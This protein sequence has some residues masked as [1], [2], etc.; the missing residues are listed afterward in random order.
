MFWL[1]FFFLFFRYALVVACGLSCP[2]T[3]GILVP[4]PGIEPIFPDS[5]LGKESTCNEGDPG[6][7]PGSGRSHGERRGYPLQYSWAFLVA[8]LVKNLPTMQ[9][10]WV[11]FLGWEDTLEKG[12]ATHSS[13]LAW[14]CSPWGHT[15]LSNFHFHVSLSLHWRWILTHWT[16]REVPQF[17]IYLFIY[18]LTYFI[19]LSIYY[20]FIYLFICLFWVSV[21]AFRI[22]SCSMWTFS[23]SMWDLVPWPGTKLGS[24]TLGPLSL[25]CWT[26]REVPTSLF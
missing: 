14:L 20:L 11:P 23:Y 3:C 12:K 13:I 9:E 7:I 24:P 5:S 1:F 10:T 16:T 2:E 26:T 6:S 15:W 22:F 21:A 25:G 19:Y 8:Q 18:L 4:W 17:F